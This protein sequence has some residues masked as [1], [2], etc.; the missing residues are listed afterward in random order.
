VANLLDQHAELDNPAIDALEAPV[1]RVEAL[2][3]PSR[4][5]ST[6]SR[7]RLISPRISSR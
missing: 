2:V 1:D 5:W 4:R 7:R 6:P 3:D